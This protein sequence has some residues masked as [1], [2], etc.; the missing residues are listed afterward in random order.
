MT[1]NVR[2]REVGYSD[3]IRQHE[4]IT[5]TDGEE[6]AVRAYLVCW[7]CTVGGYLPVNL[8]LEKRYS[9]GRP[10]VGAQLDILINRPDGTP[11]ALI[12]AKSPDAWEVEAEKYI[13][14]QLFNI[15]PHEPGVASL[16]FATVEVNGDVAPKATTIAY[17]GQKFAQWRTKRPSSEQL[18]ANYGEP[19]H[20]HYT[21]QGPRDLKRS[22]SQAELDR[23]RKRLHDVLWRGS[24]PDNQI[25]EYVVK[26]FL[27]KIST[28]RTPPLGGAT[29]SSAFT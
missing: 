16:S 28:R 26:L 13:E 10:K 19:V 25:Y 23:L 7:L 22:A 14:G 24:T 9:I 17:E 20:E 29:S 5:W 1:L 15:A 21:S 8:E 27:T 6:E 4:A 11:Y 2:T 18:P 12:E 3:E